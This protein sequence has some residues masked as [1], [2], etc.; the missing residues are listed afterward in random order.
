MGHGKFE[1]KPEPKQK[2]TAAANQTKKVNHAN[3]DKK[4]TAAPKKKL[5]KKKLMLRILIAVLA[6]LLVVLVVVAVAMNYVL[7]RISR[8]DETEPSETVQLEDEF[9]TDETVE[10]QET[11]DPNDVEFDEVELL[12]HKNIVNI[13]LIGNDA[14]DGEE[15]ARSDTMILVSLNKAN[16][17]IQLTSFMRDMYVQI[18]GYLDNKINVAFRY[19]GAELLD[20]TLEKNFGVQVDGNV[21]VNFESFVKVIDILGGVDVVMDAE[22]ASY[23]RNIHH[24][25]AVEGTNHLDGET[26]LSFARMRH[27]SGGDYSRTERQREVIAAVMESLKNSDI[28]TILEL[29]DEV[30]PYVTTDLTDAQIVNYATVGL[31]VLSKGGEIS[32]IRIPADDA[33]YGTMISGMSVL[34]PD[35]KMCQE[36]LKEFIYSD[37]E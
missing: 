34:V 28:A 1:K 20:Q 16:N 13:L 35:L 7:G 36:D 31:S 15:R 33:H 2:A 18:P 3:A 10:G 26:A 21:E 17:S 8:Y 37:A 30:L 12:D 14:R 29:I 4:S 19:G 9:E 5:D 27:L 11:M 22:E 23:V 24:F 25:D 32:S 6:V